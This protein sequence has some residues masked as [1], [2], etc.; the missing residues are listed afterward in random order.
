MDG[1]VKKIGVAKQ[2]EGGGAGGIN[3]NSKFIGEVIINN[4]L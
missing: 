1:G 3:N 2:F 4:N